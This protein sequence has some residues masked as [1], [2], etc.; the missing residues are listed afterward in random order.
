MITKEILALIAKIIDQVIKTPLIQFI[1]YFIF[2]RQ[3]KDDETIQERT[4]L[5]ILK[6]KPNIGQ[7]A[8]LAHY[9][10]GKPTFSKMDKKNQ[11]FEPFFHIIQ[12]FPSIIKDKLVPE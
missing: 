11:H 5:N 3:S 9:N 12:I 2:F 4:G 10:I 6:D 8:F 7:P 1:H